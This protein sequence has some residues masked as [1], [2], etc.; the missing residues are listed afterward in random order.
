MQDKEK[1]IIFRFSDV[2]VYVSERVLQ[3]NNNIKAKNE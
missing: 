1:L 2:L 3:K